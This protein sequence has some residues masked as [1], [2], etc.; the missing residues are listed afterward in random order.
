MRWSVVV[1]RGLGGEGTG[2]LWEHLGK[3]ASS[4]AADGS[5]RKYTLLELATHILPIR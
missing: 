5:E 2:T 3:E 1:T 4:L